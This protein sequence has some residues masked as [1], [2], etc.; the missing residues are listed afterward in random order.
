MGE[1]TDFDTHVLRICSR[2]C[3]PQHPRQITAPTTP[4]ELPLQHEC[5]VRTEA[6]E[7]EGPQSA[8]ACTFPLDPCQPGLR[9]PNTLRRQMPGIRLWQSLRVQTKTLP[10][11]NWLQRPH[12]RS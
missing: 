2:P 10:T 3:E 9:R 12:P 4:K 11:G 5:I 1:R 7:L 8:E 6:D